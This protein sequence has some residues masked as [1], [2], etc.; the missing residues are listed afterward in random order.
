[1]E[2]PAGSKRQRV[3]PRRHPA[4]DGPVTSTIFPTTLRDSSASSAAAASFSPW[5]AEIRG[6]SR[7]SRTQAKSCPTSA[8]FASGA[9][10]AKAP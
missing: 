8:R 2:P 1:M 7:P 4:S 3:D 5:T 10:L 9:R 6:R